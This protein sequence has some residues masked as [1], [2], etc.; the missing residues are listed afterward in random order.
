MR[1]SNDKNPITTQVECPCGWSRKI[2]AGENADEIARYHA[3]QVHN[4]QDA[5]RAGR[6]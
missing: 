6:F 3:I 1:G 2:N 5:V 4:N